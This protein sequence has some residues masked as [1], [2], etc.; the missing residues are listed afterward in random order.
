MSRRWP[1]QDDGS[2]A[3]ET[4]ILAPPML[5]IIAMAIIGMRIEVAGGAIEGAAHAAARAASIAGNPQAAQS[6]AFATA[7]ASLQ[8]QGLKCA[9]LQV[10]VNT[11]EFARPPGQ[12]ANVY[13]DITCVVAL[14]DVAAPGMPGSKSMNATFVSPIDVYRSRS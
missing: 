10:M 11:A 1:R 4:V 13:V 12:Q 14:A 9:Q 6:A 2:A 7:N 3:L 8:Q 5:A